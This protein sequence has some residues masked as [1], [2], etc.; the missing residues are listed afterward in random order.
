MTRDEILH[1]QVMKHNVS[2]EI[3]TAVCD[4]I[5]RRAPM[6][7]ELEAYGLSQVQCTEIVKFCDS[8][9]EFIEAKQ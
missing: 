3:M 1:T 7:L 2:K 9:A 5:T 8:L 4:V 6:T